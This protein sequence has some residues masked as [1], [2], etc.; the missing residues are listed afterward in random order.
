MMD[1]T[2][3]GVGNTPETKLIEQVFE[4]MKVVDNAGE[5]L[6]KVDYV[7][8]GDPNAATTQG[9]MN[10]GS[11]VGSAAVAPGIM[12]DTGSAGGG[13][14]PIPLD[15]NRGPDVP[16]PERSNLI[17]MGY[18][19][20]NGPGIKWLGGANYYVRADQI[21]DVTDDTVRVGVQKREVIKQD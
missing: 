10:T 13:V 8:M 17:R 21:L 1:R 6:G 9:Q 19:K 11:G 12:A 18:F 5:N 4:G 20:V 2:N 7:Q 3:Q 15:L 14:A 16:E